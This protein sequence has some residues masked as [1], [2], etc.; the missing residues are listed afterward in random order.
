MIL[1]FSKGPIQRAGE[2]FNESDFLTLSPGAQAG[3]LNSSSGVFSG[4]SIPID[5]RFLRVRFL[6][7]QTQ[8]SGFRSER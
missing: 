4:I 6:R 3:W 5:D 2:D 7:L 1:V 8:D